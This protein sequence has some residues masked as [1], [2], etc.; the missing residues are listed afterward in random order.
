MNRHR[1]LSL[2]EEIANSITHGVGLLASVIGF[3]IL[4]YVAAQDGDT[5]RVMSCTIYATTLVA[6]YAF[7]TL[8]HAIPHPRAKRVFRILDHSAIYL[9]IAGTYTPFTLVN[10][11]GAVGWTLF[12]IVW[13]MAALGIVFKAVFSVRFA[14]AS[15][16]LYVLMGWMIVGAIK[17]LLSNVA[18]GGVLWLVAGGL[19]YTTGVLFFAWQKLRYSHMIWHV[20]VFAGSVCHYF[21]V[22]WYAVPRT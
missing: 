22:L 20:F 17:P 21:A 18:L 4:V 19:L 11:R 9:L 2:G 7:S 10:M 12:G 3:P 14:V 5:W 1:E 15:T 16:V 8:Y 6:V 13:A